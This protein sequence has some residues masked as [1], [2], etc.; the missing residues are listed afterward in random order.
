MADDVQTIVDYAEDVTDA[1]APPPL[2]I[3]NYE[4]TVTGA[5]VKVSG[6]GNHYY[7]VALR[8]PPEQ[9][10]ADFDASVY[11]DGVLLFWRR[12]S[13]EDTPMGR[14]QVRQLIEALGAKGG[15][16]ID[17]NDWIGLATRVAVTHENFEGS[18]RA[19]PSKLSAL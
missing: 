13:A 16:Q 7:E 2:P 5:A 9:F 1:E 17:C 12:T 11:P 6:K 4:P 3:G 19:V 10:P 14:W 8:V 15:K 18:P